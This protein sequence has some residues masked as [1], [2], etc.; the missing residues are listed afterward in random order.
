MKKKKKN[1]KKT[2]FKIDKSSKK[3]LRFWG[4]KAAGIKSKLTSFKQILNYLNPAVFFIEK[5]NK[6]MKA[7]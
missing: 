7:N 2:R 6:K 3:S 1:E 5:Q 4:V